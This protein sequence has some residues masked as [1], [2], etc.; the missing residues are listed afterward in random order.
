M[1]RFEIITEAE[2]RQ[3]EPGSTVELAAGGQVTPLAQDTLAA[4]RVTLVRAGPI[5][6]DE[7]ARYGLRPIRIVAIGCDHTGLDLKR[8]VVR[9]VRGRGLTVE[10]LGVHTAARVDYPDVAA[11]VARFVA[12]G[13]ADAGLI[14]D[15]S[16]VGSA[17]AANKV[18]G[19]RAAMVAD[20]MAARYAREHA[21]V[22]VL[23]L[24]ATF[25]DAE[26]AGA[27]VDAWLTA[28]MREPRYV[29]RLAKIG[30]LERG[31]GAG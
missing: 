21:G 10:D 15:G 17:I 29:A 16:G 8:E 12:R 24:G 14:I 2:A 23:A 28:T 18:V 11:D 31:G 1:K 25:V 6:Q 7:L 3:L 19:I 22:N 5:T 9:H 20:P 30:R 27:I 4:R 26:R 13:Q